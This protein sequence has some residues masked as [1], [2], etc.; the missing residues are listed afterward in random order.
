MSVQTDKIMI[1]ARNKKV[2]RLFEVLDKIEAGLVLSGTEIK[3]IRGGKISFK[4]SYVT[5]RQ[6]E[7]YLVGLHIAPYE[8]AGHT[9]H[10]PDRERKLLLHRREIDTL[11]GKAEQKGLTIVPTCVY[12]K[13]AKAKIEIALARGKKVHD[14]REELKRRAI[15]RDL[16]REISKY[17]K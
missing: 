14:R 2:N 1:V 12:L 7:A 4:D 13:N 5:F 8:K 17:Y 10:E 16:D 3:S 6:G 15:Q 9:S 11:R